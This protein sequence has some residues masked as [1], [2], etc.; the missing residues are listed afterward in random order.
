MSRSLSRKKQLAYGL[1]LG[2]AIL[3]FLIAAV[4]LARRGSASR[5]YVLAAGLVAGALLLL[6]V[7]SANR[8]YFA[9]GRG[10][11]SKSML[12]PFSVPIGAI[13]VVLSQARATLQI[14]AL[15][16]GA[17]YLATLCFL[18]FRVVHKNRARQLTGVR[19]RS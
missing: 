6:A 5:W 1:G 2:V 10:G 19:V 16:L 14:G 7:Y 12:I 11:A 15:A 4:D 8:R 17:G 18:A 3:G 9:A 13:G